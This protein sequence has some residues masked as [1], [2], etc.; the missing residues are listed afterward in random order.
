[1][2]KTTITMLLGILLGT[3]L[4]APAVNAAYGVLAERSAQTV[5]VD[6]QRV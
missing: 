6:G 3:I 4:A 5:Y 1:M 2:K